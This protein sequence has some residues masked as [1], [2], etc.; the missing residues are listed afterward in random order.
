MSRNFNGSTELITIADFALGTSG[1]TVMAWVR[2]DTLLSGNRGLISQANYSGGFTNTSFILGIN[3]ISGFFMA[4]STGGTDFVEYNMGSAVTTNTWYHVCGTYDND[5]V[6]LYVNGTQHGTGNAAATGAVFNSTLDILIAASKVSG[7][8]TEFF[9]GQMARVV[10]YTTALTQTQIQSVQASGPPA[11]WGTVAPALWHELDGFLPSPEMDF[12]GNGRTGTFSATTQAADPTGYVRRW[13]YPVA[14]GAEGASVS[15]NVTLAAPSATGGNLTNDVWIAAIHTSDQN[16]MTFPDWTQIIQGNGGSTTSRLSV[17][18]HRYLGTTPNLVVTHS[19]GQT[20]IGGI[21]AYRNALASGSPVNTTGTLTAGV[22]GT[23]EVAAITPSVSNTMLVIADGSA[24][25]NPRVVPTGWLN[26]FVD[27]ANNCYISTL[28]NPDGSVGLYSRFNQ[29]GASGSHVVT[30]GTVP[31]PIS[32][33]WATVMLALAPAAGGGTLTAESGSYA[34]TGTAAALKVTRR[35]AA[36]AGTY[37]YTGTVVT[38]H[39]RMPA[40]SGSYAL[41]G[42]AATLIAPENPSLDATAG[43]YALTGSTVGLDYVA[44]IVRRPLVLIRR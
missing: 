9:D 42:S 43:S 15:G 30:Q 41:T 31:S 17:W 20:P 23:D 5:V 34:L 39:L 40:A 27:G 18:Y 7:S 32:D 11:I 35:V 19:G 2:A 25:D 4:I 21:V 3:D 13:P 38:Y 22:D 26:H 28:G 6:R 37:A 12:S 8:N 36:N 1:L 16:A 24:D 33:P 14:V 44:V 29:T 10:I